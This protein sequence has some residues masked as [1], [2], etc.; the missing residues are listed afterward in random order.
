MYL[1]EFTKLV[2][3][4]EHYGSCI[5]YDMAFIDYKSATTTLNL[6]RK[7]AC[8]KLLALDFLKKASCSHFGG[9]LT[10]LDLRGSDQHPKDLVKACALLVNYQ[11]PRTHIVKQLPDKQ[12]D[13]PEIV[14]SLLL[15][16]L[17]HPYWEQIETCTLTYNALHARKGDTMP[18]CVSRMRKWQT[19]M[20]TLSFRN[21]IS[22]SPA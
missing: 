8:N 20:L 13:H 2:D 3:T 1:E 5:G 6:K 4:T 15:S 14:V 22:L 16:N 7:G 9:L 19:M 18:T 21:P 10:D 11:L 12:M 17:Q